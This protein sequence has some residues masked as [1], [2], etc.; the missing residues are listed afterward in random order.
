[1]ATPLDMG[2]IAGGLKV[3]GKGKTEFEFVTTKGKIVKITQEAHHVPD[4]PV[5][6]VPLQITN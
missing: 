3:I 4:L 2:G 5:D 1:M 6:L